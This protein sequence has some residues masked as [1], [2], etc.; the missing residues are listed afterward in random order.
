YSAEKEWRTNVARGGTAE[1]APVTKELEDMALKAAKAVGGGIV[2][3][4]LMEDKN[5]GLVVHEVN[6]TVEFRGAAGVSKS[7]IAGAMIDYAVKVAKK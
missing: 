2:G 5:R 7:D 3:V 1:P 6:N 4:D